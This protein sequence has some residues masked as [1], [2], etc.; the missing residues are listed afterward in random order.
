MRSTGHER[1]GMIVVGLGHQSV[2]DHIP[3]I[4]GS[5]SFRLLGVADIDEA[6]AASLGEQLGVAHA[7][8][9]HSL[10]A[11]VAEAVDV[12]LVAVP[13][14]DY[15]PIIEMLARSK[16]HIIKEKP[17]AASLHDAKRLQEVVTGSGITLQVTLQRRYNPI[18]LS[19]EQ[20]I[21]RVGRIFSIE[22]RYTMNIARLDE[23]WRAS[24]L[25]SGGGALIDLGYHYVDLIVWFFGLP[26]SITCDLSTGNRE[27]QVYDVEDTALL[28]F[29]YSPEGSPEATLGSLIVSRV[30]PDKDEMLVAYGQRGSVSVRRGMVVRRDQHGEELECLE[31]RGT[32]P[33]ALMD[34]LDAFAETVRLGRGAGVIE[35]QYL[36]QCAFVEAAYRSAKSHTAVDPK[37]VLAELLS[38]GVV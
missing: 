15:L 29:G 3:A 23:G 2:D 11:N 13:H 32:W 6:R 1:L 16:I 19:F 21:K 10:L 34:Q 27:G 22:G 4:L 12:A 20:L 36:E 28:H 17:F 5:S 24:S 26:D 14:A 35:R 30:Y 25:Y 31:R 38:G 8:S 18:Y 33:S 9:A 7:A 37:G